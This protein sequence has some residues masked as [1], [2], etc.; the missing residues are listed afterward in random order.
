ML[1]SRFYEHNIISYI[2]SILFY[3]YL[4]FEFIGRQ[5]YFLRY[6]RTHKMH[7]K[8]I[9]FFTNVLIYKILYLHNTL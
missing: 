2:T 3:N 9:Q 8:M 7:N 6:T 4:M 5:Y 1:L